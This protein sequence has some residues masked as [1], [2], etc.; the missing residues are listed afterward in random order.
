[1]YYLLLLIICCIIGY[2]LY[3]WIKSNKIYNGGGQYSWKN[4]IEIYDKYRPRYNKKAIDNFIKYTKLNINKSTIADIG[5]GTGI[6]TRQLLKYE[7]KKIYS[8]DMDS[9]MIEFSKSN[10]IRI[11]PSICNSFHL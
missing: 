2:G 5:S 6:L 10:R 9:D 1:M 8:I 4:K 11:K 7:P 3:I